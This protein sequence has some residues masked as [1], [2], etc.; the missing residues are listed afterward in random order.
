MLMK[1]IKKSLL[2]FLIFTS[3]AAANIII[4]PALDA[5]IESEIE[6][7]KY[8]SLIIA[9]IE[10]GETL[11]KSYGEL[12]DGAGVKPNA[13]TLFEFSSNSKT[14]TA[15]LLGIMAARGD[16]SLDD[17]VNKYLPDGIR[18]KPFEDVDISLQDLATHM[19]GLP[20][21]P[22][23]YSI[24]EST[25]TPRSEYTVHDLWNSINAFEPTR[26][27]G[28]KWQYSSFNY[29]VLSHVLARHMEQDYYT[30]VQQE[31]LDPLGMSNTYLHLPESEK[32][33]FA[34]GHLASGE[35]TSNLVDHGALYAAGSMFI[36]LNDA[37]KFLRAHMGEVKTP[38]D[39]GIALTHP[40]Y[41][42]SHGMGLAWENTT[43]SINRNHFGTGGGHRAYIGFNKDDPKRRG[44]IIF[45]NTRFGIVDIGHRALNPDHPL[46]E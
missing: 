39:E 9:Y 38:I 19:S 18:L 25:P 7:G 20:L 29:G 23:D 4:E 14:M 45:T 36:T 1:Y 41:D 43:G 17:P 2:L 42:T 12:E 32:Y 11:I 27:S 26:K 46:P 34:Q 16:V 8:Q 24:D 44:V 33:R 13:D 21:F 3:K 22:E 30:L 28:E 40:L 10:N 15:T 35:R 37:I 5:H 6:A 31:I